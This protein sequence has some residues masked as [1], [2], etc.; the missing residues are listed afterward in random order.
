MEGPGNFSN[1]IRSI[2]ARKQEQEIILC[3]KEAQEDAKALQRIADKLEKAEG[4]DITWGGRWTAAIENQ[5]TL[6][7]CG[8]QRIDHYDVRVWIK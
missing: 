7:G 2:R 3:S 6:N 5:L 8:F 1:R 4:D